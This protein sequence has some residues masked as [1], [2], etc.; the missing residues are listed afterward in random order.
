MAELLAMLVPVL[1]FG[2]AWGVT[3]A[4][5]RPGAWLYFLDQPNERSLHVTPTPRTG[6]VGVMA[7]LLAGWALVALAGLGS[8]P[9]AAALTGAGGL[10][11]VGLADD[12]FGLSARLRLLAQLLVAGAYLALLGPA[13]GGLEW[14]A[15]GLGLVWM[16]NL[17]NFMDGSDGLAGGMALFGFAA[18]AVA[19]ALAGQAGLALVCT[20]VAA[21]AAGF[22]VFNFHPARIFMG[23]VGSVPL[24]FLAGA[25]GLAGRESGAWPLWFPLLVFA[26]FILDATVTLL[27]RALRGERIWQAHRTHYYQRLVQMGLGHRRTALLAYAL[28]AGTGGAGVLALPLG[29]SLQCIIITMCVSLHLALGY[30]IDSAWRRHQTEA[31]TP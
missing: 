3:R 19:A 28:M 29:F 20:G 11:L 30:R 14:L 22:L 1:A 15:L 6:G 21:A 27:R 12:R 17:Y 9:L 18:F 24:G 4:C 10:A 2:V 25:L 8:L 13:G 26:P 7:G 23:D 5:C 16:G 31:P